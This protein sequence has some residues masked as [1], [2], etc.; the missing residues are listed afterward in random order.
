MSKTLSSIGFVVDSS[1]M[2]LIRLIRGFLKLISVS[3]CLEEVIFGLRILL[4]VF[5]LD[6]GERYAHMR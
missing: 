4:R 5:M 2:T 3:N 1:Q 6:G